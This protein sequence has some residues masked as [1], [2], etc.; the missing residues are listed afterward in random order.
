MRRGMSLR[1]RGL[2]IRC[3][4]GEVEGTG[5]KKKNWWGTSLSQVDLVRGTS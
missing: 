1:R 2:G 4:Q 5:K 3:E